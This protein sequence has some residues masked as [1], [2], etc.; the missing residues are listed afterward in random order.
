MLPGFV[1]SMWERSDRPTG[2]QVVECSPGRLSKNSLVYHIILSHCINMT[3]VYYEE[4][5]QQ[6]PLGS[7]FTMCLLFDETNKV[8]HH[9]KLAS[10]CQ[11][12]SKYHEIGT[13]GFL[14]LRDRWHQFSAFIADS[15]GI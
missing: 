5:L 15:D 7:S 9:I 10:V 2:S 4:D 12:K 14:G 1:V 11:K 3:V 13:D 6:F 8:C